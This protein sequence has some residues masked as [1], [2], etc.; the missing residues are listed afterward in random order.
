M[1]EV[2][3]T[4]MSGTAA[5]ELLYVLEQLSEA[6]EHDVIAPAIAS[7]LLELRK[8]ELPLD[9][10]CEKRFRALCRHVR[11]HL[12]QLIRTA[13]PSVVVVARSTEDEPQF[14]SPVLAQ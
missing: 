2:D 10:S 11:P 6:F 8:S 14:A 13:S 1:N 12:P 7:G 9:A 3:R 4:S 5:A